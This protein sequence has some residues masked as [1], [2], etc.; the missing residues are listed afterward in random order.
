MV[1]ASCGEARGP[2]EDTS[3]APVIVSEHTAAGEVAESVATAAPKTTKTTAAEGLPLRDRLIVPVAG[4][5]R[6]NLP[7]NFNEMRGTRRHDAMDILAPRGTQVLSATNGRVVKLHTSAA[8]G[9]MVYA[10]D[11]TERYVLMYAHLD[12]YAAGLAEK[13]PLKQGQVIGYVGTTG[14]APPNTPHLHFAITRVDSVKYWWKGEPLDP[15]PLLV[16][17]TSP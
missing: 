7:D 16:G 8:G 11:A 9:L 17:T 4:V 6:D 13:M 3:Y 14:N 1:L 12:R 5:S 2:K 15:R 10:A